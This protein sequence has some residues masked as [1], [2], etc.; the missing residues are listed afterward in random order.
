MV[1][2]RAPHTATFHFP[3]K[4]EIQILLEKGGGL[5]RKVKLWEIR[6]YLVTRAST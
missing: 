6:E 3:A 5:V 4:G 1:L 2:L